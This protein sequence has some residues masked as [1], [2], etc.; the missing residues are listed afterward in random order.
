LVVRHAQVFRDKQNINLLTG[1]CA[2]NIDPGQQTVSGVTLEGDRFKFPYDKLLIATGSAAVRPDLVGIDRPEVMVLKSLEDGREIKK[3]LKNNRIQKAVIIGMGYI[4]L[5]MCESLVSLDIAVDMVKPGPVFLPW[6][7]QSMAQAVR[8]ELEAKGVGIYAG[9]AV[10]RIDKTDEDLKVVCPDLTISADMVLVGIGVTPCS[11]IAE[12]AGLELGVQKSIAVDRNLRTSNQNIYA[13]GDC[14]DAY[15]VVTEEKTW[16]PLALRANRA[17]W[18]VADNVCGKSVSLDGVAGTAVFRV[19]DFEVARTGLNLNEAEAFGFEPVENM[20]KSRSKAHAH[21][22]NTVI[23]VNMIG[24]KNSG[25]L[26][27][28]QMVGKEGVAHRINAVAV[29]LHSRMTV[30]QFSQAD[31]AYAPPFGPTWDPTLT[32]ANQLLK[33]MI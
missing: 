7:E 23:W 30:E 18:A 3:L 22:G 4:A 25:R 10:E 32:A 16:I 20:I 33:K 28:A 21:P 15:H 13:A 24:D 29:A 17:G 1:H 8:E 26:L 11:Q 31:L 12:D 27:G 5:E 9:H 14:A 2:E 6:L 19:F